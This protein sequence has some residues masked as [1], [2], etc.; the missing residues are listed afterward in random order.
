MPESASFCPACGRRMK[1]AKAST[2]TAGRR[3]ENIAA[4]LAYF[5][6][7]P[8][9]IFLWLK[10]FRE[11]HFVRYHSIQSLLFS[12]ATIVG[13][14]VLRLAAWVFTLIPLAGPLL[15]VV[16]S[17]LAGF[18]VFLLWL[19]LVIKAFRGESFKLPLLGDLAER[20]VLSLG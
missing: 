10:P 6:F 15:V 14:V 2:A 8:A 5:T 11:N 7:I 13:V 18:A 20:A 12:A 4:T 9:I 1:S 3:P 16:V 19:V 17:V